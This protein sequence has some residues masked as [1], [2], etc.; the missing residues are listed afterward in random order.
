MTQSATDPTLKAQ[1]ANASAAL[2]EKR[3]PDGI[4]AQ[5]FTENETMGISVKR[6][7]RFVPEQACA[8][9]FGATGPRL[10]SL[11][12]SFISLHDETGTPCRG[13]LLSPQTPEIASDEV[14]TVTVKARKDT[15]LGTFIHDAKNQL[16]PNQGREIGK[17]WNTDTLALR[18]KP[19]STAAPSLEDIL[20]AV[21]RS[22]DASAQ[23][24]PAEP[25][26]VADEPLADEHDDD[27]PMSDEEPFL[28]LPS[29]QSSRSKGKSKGK[30][31]G[32]DKGRKRGADTAV[33]QGPAASDAASMR[34]RS[35]VQR[36]VPGSSASVADRDGAA[37][38]AASISP[39]DKLRS[40][41][42]KYLQQVS[43]SKLV[44]NEKWSG[45]DL[46]Q[47]KR[48]L[49]AMQERGVCSES[50]QLASHLNLA[51]MTRRLSTVNIHSLASEERSHLLNQLIAHMPEIPDEWGATLLLL[52]VKDHL[53]SGF[54]QGMEEKWAAAVWPPMS[55]GRRQE[56][57]LFWN[58]R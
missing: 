43:L 32:K 56:N 8:K 36:G 53:A 16:V 18:P 52:W 1:I 35:P 21:R 2:K 48:V 40:Q 33:R 44:C 38:V 30:G 47:A 9:V 22:Q 12:Y 46:H 4:Q 24:A 54:A 49:K 27:E 3:I 14:R 34:S 15:T 19:F 25:L 28:Q 5:N 50:V 45:Q 7:F 58:L 6:T 57:K 31:K 55:G 39:Q 20:H 11:G 29:L 51:E 13:I 41:G 10:Q 37:S 23:P 42:Q 17:W 26:Q